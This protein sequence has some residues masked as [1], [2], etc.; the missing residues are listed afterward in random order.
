MSFRMLIKNIFSSLA[1]FLALFLILISLTSCVPKDDGA[2]YPSGSSNYQSNSNSNY[3][4]SSNSNYEPSPSFSQKRSDSFKEDNN[5]KNSAN[6]HKY[7]MRRYCVQDKC[8]TPSVIEIGSKYRGVASWYGEKFH[9][10]LTSNGEIYDMYAMSAAHKNLPL[11]TY[12]RV[13][14]LANNKSVIVRVN[15]R[16]PFH[17]SRLIDLSYSAAYKLDMLK[18]GTAKVKIVAITDFSPPPPLVKP[19]NKNIKEH[20]VK[21]PKQSSNIQR[22]AIQPVVKLAP[23]S[24]TYIQV[25]ATSKNTLAQDTAKNVNKTISKILNN[26]KNYQ[27]STPKFDQVYKVVIGPIKNSNELNDLLLKLKENG[28]PNAFR[29]NI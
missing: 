23:T 29:K 5:I 27:I 1:L 21:V 18:S 14:N 13:T 28:Y 25:F 7:T 2:Y 4:Q 3:Q 17:Q 9:G 8:Y 10:H 20:V 6:M 24:H 16:G 15:D 12:V 11:P 22:N 19:I 26:K